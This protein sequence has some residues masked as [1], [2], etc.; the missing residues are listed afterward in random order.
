MGGQVSRHPEKGRTGQQD[1]SF[2]HD[3]ISTYIS[4]LKGASGS[5][6]DWGVQG[7]ARCSK[8]VPEVLF[9]PGGP[10]NPFLGGGSE[11]EWFRRSR[12]GEGLWSVGEKVMG[13]RNT[14]NAD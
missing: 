10:L 9:G 2:N 4:K 12:A 6:S 3:L 14:L 5:L 7:R 13:G 8:E 1:I 11:I